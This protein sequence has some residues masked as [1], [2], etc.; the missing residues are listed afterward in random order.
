MKITEKTFKSSQ[1]YG[2]MM[3]GRMNLC[4]EKVRI[5]IKELTDA[6]REDIK[7]E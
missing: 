3:K 4:Q 7:N 6:G 1:N 5:F 2:H